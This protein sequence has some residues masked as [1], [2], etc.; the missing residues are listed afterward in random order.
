MNETLSL[1]LRRSWERG[2]KGEAGITIQPDY[3]GKSVPSTP[4][5]TPETGTQV[6]GLGRTWKCLHLP[7]GEGLTLV[8]IQQLHGSTHE[9][10]KIRDG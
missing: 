6:Q 3:L 5:L 10:P 9:K 7:Q 1:P 2:A 4:S 8:E